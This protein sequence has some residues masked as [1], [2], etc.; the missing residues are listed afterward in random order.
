MKYKDN[1][2]FLLN[3]LLFVLLLSVSSPPPQLFF[4]FFNKNLFQM[5]WNCLLDTIVSSNRRCME[6]CCPFNPTMTWLECRASSWPDC[7]PILTSL[8]STL[9]PLCLTSIMMVSNYCLSKL[10]SLL[11]KLIL[12]CFVLSWWWASVVCLT[13]ISLPTTLTL[14]CSCIIVMS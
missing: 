8:L 13:R 11:T 4:F 5:F 7:S 12:P 2:S 9:T 10:I 1:T 3:S 14:Q 6:K